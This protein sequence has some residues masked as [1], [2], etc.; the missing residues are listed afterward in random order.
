MKLELLTDALLEKYINLQPVNIEKHWLK[1]REQKTL[2]FGYHFTSS[3]VYSS[4]IEGNTMDL[5]SYSKI[6]SSG[7]DKKNKQFI[8]IEDLKK[9]YKFAAENKL[10]IKNLLKVHKI[11]SEHI[12]EDKKYKGQ[13]RDRSVYIFN[14]GEKIYTGAEPEILENEID[15]FFDDTNLLQKSQ[16]TVDEIYYFASIVHLIFVYIHPFADCNGRV[17]RLLEKWFLAEKLGEKAWF[18]QSEKFYQK[19]LKQYYKNLDIGKSYDKLI[20]NKSLDFLVMLP[21]ALRTK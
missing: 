3:A 20:F 17:S 21:M 9:A 11:I 4:M 5:D 10:N 13:L 7:M 19:K 12:I 8:E 18:I 6:S 1:L 2:D 16:L 14:K 15:K